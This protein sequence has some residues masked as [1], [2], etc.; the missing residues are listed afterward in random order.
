MGHIV[1]KVCGTFITQEDTRDANIKKFKCPKC[2]KYELIEYN[3]N[4]ERART[5]YRKLAQNKEEH[6]ACSERF[7]KTS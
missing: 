6:I 5:N 3:E 4:H 2:N 7:L 1:C